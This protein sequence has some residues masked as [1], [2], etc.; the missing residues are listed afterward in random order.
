MFSLASSKKAD[1]F[2][3]GRSYMFTAEEQTQAGLN[4]AAYVTTAQLPPLSGLC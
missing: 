4:P 3:G 1:T 2:A